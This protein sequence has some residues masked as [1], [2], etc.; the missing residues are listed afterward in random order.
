MKEAPRIV[1]ESAIVRVATW[2]EVFVA[3]W[4]TAGTATDVRAVHAQQ[5]AFAQQIGQGERMISISIVSA[6]AA[7]SI[8]AQMRQAVEEGTREFKERTKAAAIVIVAAGFGASA[9]RSLITALVLV[10]RPGYPTRVFDGEDA[11]SRWAATLLTRG[12]ASPVYEADLR[13]ALHAVTSPPK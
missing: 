5:R 3:L 11:A 4:H 9:V 2:R 6:R 7:V 12:L 8:D 10:N 1:L 13:E